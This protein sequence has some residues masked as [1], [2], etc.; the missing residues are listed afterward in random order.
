[1]DNKIIEKYKTKY[2]DKNIV[3]IEGTK[4]INSS[5]EKKESEKRSI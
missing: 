5:N 4:I 2:N 3:K 1:M